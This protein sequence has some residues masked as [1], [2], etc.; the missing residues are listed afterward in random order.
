MTDS[1]L[2]KVH[3]FYFSR[4]ICSILFSFE[5]FP[6]PVQLSLDRPSCTNNQKKIIF[7]RS[8]PP[9]PN[10]FISHILICYP[11]ILAGVR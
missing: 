8:D 3:C 4:P 6:A 11:F 9:T 7:I 2:H 10:P 1:F 5:L